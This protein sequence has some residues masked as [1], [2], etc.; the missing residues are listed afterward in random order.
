[1]KKSE[2]K[3]RRGRPLTDPSGRKESFHVRL[4]PAEQAKLLRFGATITEGIKAML[5]RV[6]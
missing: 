2:P 1:M 3:R 4:S 6:K 5:A